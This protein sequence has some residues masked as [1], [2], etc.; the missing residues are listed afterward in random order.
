MRDPNIVSMHYL[1]DKIIYVPT[2][3]KVFAPEGRFAFLQ[4][5]LWSL[6]SKFGA[7]Q[8]HQDQKAIVEKIEFS[9]KEFA[10]RLL[11]AY[12]DCFPNS[13]PRH[14]YIGPVEFEELMFVNP[15]YI[16]LDFDVKMNYNQTMFNLPV[17][18]VPHMKGCL[19]V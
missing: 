12:C 13:K 8:D 15:N 16:Q 4:K 6:L 2:D 11:D 19:I 3:A 18:V 5:W 17:T 10:D 9:K 14:V 1:R 7:L